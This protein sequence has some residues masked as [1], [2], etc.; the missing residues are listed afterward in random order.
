MDVSGRK[1]I[2]LLVMAK[3][4]DGDVDRTQD[5]QFIGLLEEAALS[6]EK[7]P[8]LGDQQLN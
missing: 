1:F 2:Q 7:C 6:L 5:G 4:D 3:D 8:R